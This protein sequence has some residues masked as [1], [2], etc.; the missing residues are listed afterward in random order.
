MRLANFSEE[1]L[2]SGP[3]PEIRFPEGRRVCHIECSPAEYPALY[4]IGMNDGCY[5]RVAYGALEPETVATGTGGRT[6]QADDA[7]ARGS[8]SRC[9]LVIIA[10]GSFVRQLRQSPRFQGGQPLRRA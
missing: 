3:R 6:P 5:L 7:V 1:W 2:I 10:I 8:R 9:R 4:Q